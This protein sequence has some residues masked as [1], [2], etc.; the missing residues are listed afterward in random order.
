LDLRTRYLGLELD[1]P[2]VVGSSPLVDDLDVVRQLEDAGAAAIV[3]HSL[4]E[5]QLVGE[6][7]A[8][9]L[10]LDAPSEAYLGAREYL[11]PAEDYALSPDAYYEQLA[12]IKQA[13]AI[14]VIASLNGRTPGYWVQAAA[15]LES[16]GADAVELNLYR[17]ATD[18]RRGA[19]ELEREVVEVVRAAHE[20]VRLP[21]AVKLSPYFTSLAHLVARLAG[22]GAGGVVLFNRFYQ[23]DID[24]ETLA[25][26]R[27]LHFSDPTELLLRLRWLAILRGQVGISLAASGGVHSAG[28][29]VKAL[30]AGA[31]TVQM[32][33]LLM[34]EGAAGLARLKSGLVEWL[35]ERGYASVEEVR[36]LLALDRVVDPGAYER[37]NYLR[38]LQGPAGG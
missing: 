2:L 7:I 18:P 3:M 17:L 22:A 9:E 20:S 16:A 28:D 21:I 13:I 19:E 34:R 36:G 33:S 31:D 12:R 15:Y 26:E 8:A 11:P 24:L 38:L 14:P 32:V 29:A 30:L 6:Q 37:A 1:N 35:G 4:F 27:R 25:V 23:P 10:P 5:E